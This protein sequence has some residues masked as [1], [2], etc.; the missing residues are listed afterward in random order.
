LK[1][2]EQIDVAGSQEYLNDFI[3]ESKKEESTIGKKCSAYY[4]RD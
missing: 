3:K 1:K 2:K 4:F